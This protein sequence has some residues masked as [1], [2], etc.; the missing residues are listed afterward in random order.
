MGLQPLGRRASLSF[1]PTLG[2]TIKYYQYNTSS[3]MPTELFT[4]KATYPNNIVIPPV[5]LRHPAYY[6]YVS[7]WL[8]KRVF[9]PELPLPPLS[10]LPQTLRN[11][12]SSTKCPHV[13]FPFV[14]LSH[15]SKVIQLAW[16]GLL[17]RWAFLV[18]TLLCE[19][20]GTSSRRKKN[21]TPNHLFWSV[22]RS[23][24]PPTHPP[25]YPPIKR[26]LRRS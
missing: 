24:H 5:A 19:T 4:S 1:P 26:R 13:G 20:L 12:A 23:Y 14:E 9:N 25:T 21:N 2:Y 17:S 3:L 22:W 15:Q 10:S 18:A 16:R 8:S 6:S 11:T 7:H